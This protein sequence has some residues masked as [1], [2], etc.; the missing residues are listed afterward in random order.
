MSFISYSKK[1]AQKLFKY[2]SS[3]NNLIIKQ[4]WGMKEKEEEYKKR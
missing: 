2:L 3:Y 4:R 1:T